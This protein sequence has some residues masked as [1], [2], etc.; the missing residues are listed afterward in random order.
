MDATKALD[1]VATAN[2]P[3]SN[4]YYYSTFINLIYKE[5]FNLKK[6]KKIRKLRN[7][8]TTLQLKK[9]QTVERHTARWIREA[10]AAGE[11]YHQVYYWVQKNVQTLVKSLGQEDVSCSVARKVLGPE[12][13]IGI[14]VHNIEQARAA[15]VAGADYLGVGPI[16][17]TRTKLNAEEPCGLE[18]LTQIIIQ[19]AVFEL[20]NGL[21]GLSCQVFKS[22]PD[23]QST[24]DMVA[25]NAGFATLTTF[26]TCNLF[27]FSVQL[28]D[29]P[30]EAT[31]LLGRLR[32]L[33]SR[34]IGHDPIRAMGRHLNPETLHLMVFGKTFDLDLFA[35]P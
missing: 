3:E 10:L 34:I 4:H 30:A 31:H 8:L 9:L 14:S 20:I 22:N 18:L 16:Y 33:S 21:T 5:L 24:A 11:D 28:L 1:A 12:K 25:L 19:Q 15:V 17:A 29:F 13:I 2:N 6:G 7:R 32:G 35:M 23:Q 26:Q 27:A